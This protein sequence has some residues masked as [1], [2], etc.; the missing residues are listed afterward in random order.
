MSKNKKS[1][2]RITLDGFGSV[3]IAART[4]GNAVCL[5]RRH[6]RAQ[7]PTNPHTGGWKNVHIENEN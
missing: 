6:F 7:T 5:A 3:T 2:Y 1:R 4:R